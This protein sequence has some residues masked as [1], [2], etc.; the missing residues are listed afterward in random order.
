[1]ESFWYCVL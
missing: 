1:L